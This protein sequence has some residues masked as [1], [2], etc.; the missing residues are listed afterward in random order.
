MNYRQLYE[1]GKSILEKKD[2]A[3][4][5]LSYRLGKSET[6]LQHSISLTEYKKTSFLLESSTSK[7]QE[8]K[9]ELSSKINTLETELSKRTQIIIALTVLFV[10][11][12]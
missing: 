8:D 2:A 5:E 9:T 12:L 7:S 11:V 6:E 1:E 3:I 10:L 4:Q